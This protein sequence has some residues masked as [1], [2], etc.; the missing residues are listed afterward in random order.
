MLDHTS[1]TYTKEDHEASEPD[2]YGKWQNI[3]SA[4]KDGS[5]F[6][7]YEDGY[8][9]QVCYWDKGHDESG[10]FRNAHHG[11]R[12]THWMYLPDKPDS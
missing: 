5:S 6:L 9:V 12:P 1:P 4:P 8:G 11:W 2:F 7:A 10:G 3:N